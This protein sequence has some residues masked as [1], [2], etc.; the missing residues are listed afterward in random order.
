M[1]IMQGLLFS[2]MWIKTVTEEDFFKKSELLW[3]NCSCPGPPPS[4]T[5][6]WDLPWCLQTPVPCSR[7]ASQGDTE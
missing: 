4:K 3:A 1:F 7:S 5:Q 2:L 6:F